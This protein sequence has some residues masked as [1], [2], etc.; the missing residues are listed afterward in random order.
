MKFNIKEPRKN[1]LFL[2]RRLGYFLRNDEQGEYNCVRSLSDKGYPRFH[3][4][5]KKNDELLIFNL[6]LDQKKSSYKGSSA[7]S[8]EYQGE[9]VEREKERI[10]KIIKS[11]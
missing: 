1:I 5:I 7:H 11:F 6:H 8:G 3:L 10:I 2:V 9:L 4:F